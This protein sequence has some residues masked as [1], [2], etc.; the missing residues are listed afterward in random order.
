MVG[1]EE[2][3]GVRWGRGERTLLGGPPWTLSPYTPLC[4]AP[5]VFWLGLPGQVTDPPASV[6]LSVL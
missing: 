5:V 4:P 1:L 6:S 3:L 2:M